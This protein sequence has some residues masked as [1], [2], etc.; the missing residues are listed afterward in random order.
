MHLIVTCG[1][2]IADRNCGMMVVQRASILC[3]KRYLAKS[4]ERGGIHVRQVGTS[5]CV[6]STSFA[7]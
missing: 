6:T 7:T 1:F 5:F 2:E 3:L 4:E